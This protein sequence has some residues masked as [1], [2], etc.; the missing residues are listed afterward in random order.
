MGQ[1]QNLAIERNGLG[2]P[3]KIQDGTREGTVPDFDSL[4]LPVPRDKTGQS[5]KRH[6][7]TRKGRSKT[8][9]EVLKQ[10]KAV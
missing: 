7:K 8:E 5:R 1:V 3:V 10:E 9:K 6:S 2:Q 4:S